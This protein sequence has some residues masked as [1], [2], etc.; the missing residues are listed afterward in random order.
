M[1][2]PAN[3]KIS[4]AELARWQQPGSII[5]VVVDDIPTQRSATLAYITRL[6]ADGVAMI[7][8]RAM[9]GPASP[10]VA[11]APLADLVRNEFH[12]ATAI[13]ADGASLADL[14]TCIAGG[15]SDLLIVRIPDT[16]C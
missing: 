14:Q 15:R 5:A 11:A 9:A 13:M 8:V 2:P 3:T 6:Q 16:S 1:V 7:C 10:R 4:A 12:L